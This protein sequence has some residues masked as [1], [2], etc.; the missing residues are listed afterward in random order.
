MVGQTP[1]LRGTPSCRFSV[2]EEAHRGKRPARGPAADQGAD[3]GVRPTALP[4]IEIRKTMRHEG[5][6][7]VANSDLAGY[8]KKPRHAV[9]TRACVTMLARMLPA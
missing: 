5:K 7:P 3:Q 2:A 8:A 9:A 4:A 1:G 6:V